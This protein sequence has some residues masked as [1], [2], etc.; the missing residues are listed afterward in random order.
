MYLAAAYG[1]T[2]NGGNACV[3]LITYQRFNALVQVTGAIGDWLR[4]RYSDHA[5]MDDTKLSD[6]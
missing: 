2:S 1:P 4:I 6:R 5:D 3:Y